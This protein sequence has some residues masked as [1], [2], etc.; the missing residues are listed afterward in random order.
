MLLL[1]TNAKK[2][3]FILPLH[4]LNVFVVFQDLES[5]SIVDEVKPEL[6]S[7]STS[8]DK[9][10]NCVSLAWSADGQT[11]FAGYTDD[12]IRVWQVTRNA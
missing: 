3:L 12:V 9:N 2:V 11:L 7:M 4:N 6:I 10:P 8:K 5:K 1:E